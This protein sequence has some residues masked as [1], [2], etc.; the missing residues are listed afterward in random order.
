V[1]AREVHGSRVAGLPRRDCVGARSVAARPQEA[2]RASRRAVECKGQR[3]ERVG[4]AALELRVGASI[5]L[6]RTLRGVCLG[7]L[8]P[9]LVTVAKSSPDPISDKDLD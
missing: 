8:R 4:A 6:T 7:I 9:A 5:E 3:D 1:A 2:E